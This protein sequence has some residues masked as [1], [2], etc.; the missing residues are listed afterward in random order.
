[1]RDLERGVYIGEILKEREREMCICQR[2][3]ERDSERHVIK[4][5]G[6]RACHTL[7]YL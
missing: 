3:Y 5:V 6:T 4:S 2:D 7:V 1:M